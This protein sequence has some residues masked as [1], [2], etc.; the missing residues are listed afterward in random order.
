MV[1]GTAGYMS[2]EQVRG[3]AV[4]ARSDIFSL[5]TILYEMLTGRPPF[6]RET[7]AETMTAIL[8]EDPPPLP[9]DVSP[10][11]AR[12]VARCL[13]K[14]REMRFQSARDL[15]FALE[16][17]SETGVAA[18]LAPAPGPLRGHGFRGALPWIAAAALAIGLAGS[19]AWN[20]RRTAPPPPPV[21]R[22]ALALPAGQLLNGNGGGHSLAMSPDGTRLA[23]LAIRLYLRTMS[24]TDAKAMPGT[25]RYRG[26]R[27]PVF[28]P[29]G[30]SIAFYALADQTLKR[31]TVTGDTVSTICQADSPTGISW[32]PE[33]ILFGQGR[34]GI[35]RVSASGGT[36]ELVVRVNDGEVAQTPQMLPDGQHV[37]FTLA[38]GTARDRS[39]RAHV[40][41]QS[42]KSGERK[43]LIEGGSDARY[44]PT[45][46][47]VYALSGSLYAVPFNA[48][49]LEVNG[50][51][52]PIVEGVS[53][54]TAAVTGT[55]N[56]AFSNTGSLVYVR[57]PVSASALL[58]IG[59]M[60]RKGKVEPLKL[61]AGHLRVAP[62]VS[63]RQAPR[64]CERR[65]QRSDRLDLR[66]L[67]HTRDAAPHVRREQPFSDLDVGQPARRFSV[68]PRRRPRDLL[69]ACRW[70]RCRTPHQAG[71]RRVACPR[72]LVS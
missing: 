31:A 47:I 8:K 43:T 48:R 44:V 52:V 15:A 66:P 18:G 23:Y 7:A 24:E 42:L 11:L 22:F 55:A 71:T 27:E 59:L 26:L 32:G 28:S 36:P 64:G 63:R 54:D 13:E 62:C 58:D 50:A 1:V 34:N 35:M 10:A 33:G 37:L 16:G 68:G 17:L 30:A 39:D 72:I 19:L 4:D 20:L 25:E 67:R 40:V 65:R 61:P 12:I 53:R 41:V 2:P 51:P 56:F 45:G 46:H 69:A 70:R 29:D 38:A 5:G 49:R 9:P 60:D 57:G 21:T 3:T 6:T 14:T